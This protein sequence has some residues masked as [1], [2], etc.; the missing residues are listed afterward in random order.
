MKKPFDLSLFL[1]CCVISAGIILAG[2]LIS[3]EMPDTTKVPSNLAVTTTNHEYGNEF[4]NY[5]S[6]YEVT[7]YLGI[8]DEDVNTLIESGQLD[9]V[10]T[11]LGANL[12][13]SKERLDKWMEGQFD[14]PN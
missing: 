11:Q 7:A 13:F 6:K 10:S 5:L 14:F 8:T 12:V 9:E 3:K 2:F 4:G 1:G